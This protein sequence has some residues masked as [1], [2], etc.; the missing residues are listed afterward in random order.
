M[1]NLTEDIEMVNLPAPYSRG[2]R[3]DINCIYSTCIPTKVAKIIIPAPINGQPTRCLLDTGS[4]LSLMGWS[5]LTTLTNDKTTHKK[6]AIK[7]PPPSLSAHGVT[8][9]PLEIL[10][11]VELNL[12]FPSG[13]TTVE[14]ILVP[15]VGDNFDVILGL[16]AICQ[17]PPLT[18]DMDKSIVSLGSNDFHFESPYAPVYCHKKRTI[19]AH[20]GR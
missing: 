10:G 4:S 3:L 19:P 2:Y 6:I 16:D 7:D 9:H 8:G 5:H 18:I 14:D 17:Y 12:D 13:T 20:C 11:T 1:V 15:T